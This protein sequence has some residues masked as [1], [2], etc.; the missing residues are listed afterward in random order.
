PSAPGEGP[1]RR[2]RGG[3]PAPGPPHLAPP[4]APPPA[5]RLEARIAIPIHWGTL[6]PIGRGEPPR[7]PADDFAAAVA[8]TAPACTARILE[9]G[10]TLPFDA[11]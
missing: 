5:P 9:P 3:A 4:R 10:G 1:A 2:M 6:W 7:E 8:E 11:G